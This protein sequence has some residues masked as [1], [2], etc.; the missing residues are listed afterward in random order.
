[1]KRGFDASEELWNIE[2]LHNFYT[3]Y[4]RELTQLQ[5]DLGLS[6]AENEVIT[7][8]ILESL[9]ERLKQVSE[10]DQLAQFDDKIKTGWTIDDLINA[11]REIKEAC[12]E[13]NDLTEII[14]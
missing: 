1:M 5:E 9:G 8:K 3:Q 14:F 13:P 12:V 4:Q 11:E 10:Y 2:T 7:M 6:V